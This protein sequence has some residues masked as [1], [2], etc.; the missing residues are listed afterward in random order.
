[1]QVRTGY[2]GDIVKEFAGPTSATGGDPA[3]VGDIDGLGTEDVA[4]IAD[5]IQI[6]KAADGLGPPSLEGFGTIAVDELVEV[7]ITKGLPS[8][9]ALLLLGNSGAQVPMLGGVLQPAPEAA[10]PLLLLP[11]GSS[12]VKGRWPAGLP[13]YF[14]IWM[15]A[16]IMDPAG[17]EGWTCTNGL[18]GTQVSG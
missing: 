5:G 1:L 3:M 2:G 12:S 6:F 16:W 4:L 7:V 9:F 17:P 13:A 8:G 15:Q 18:I 11:D 10:I 14:T